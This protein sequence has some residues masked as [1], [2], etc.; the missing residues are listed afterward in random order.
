MS[1][2]LYRLGGL[3]ARRAWLVLLVWACIVA[4]VGAGWLLLGARTSNDIRLPGT[5]TQRATD[6]LAREF[7]PQQNGQS[8]VVFHVADGALTDPRAKRSVQ[9]SVRRMRAVPHVTS[10]MSPFDRGARSLLMSDDEKTAVAQVLLDVNGGQV[11]RALA[12]EVMAAA[13]PARDAGIQVEAGGVLGVRLSEEKSRRSEMI[14][15]GVGIVILAVTFGTLA[16]AGMPIVTAVVALVTGLGLIGLLGHVADIPV[17]APTLATMLGLGVGIDYALFIVF[18]YRDELHGG[19]SVREAVA[20]AMATSGSAVVF[21][22]VTVII[23]LLSLLVARVPLLGAM[24]WASALAVLVAVLTAITFLPA[25]LA[26]VGRRIDALRL[27]WRRRVEH[28]PDGDNIWARWAGAVTRH[29]WISLIAS[30]L[31]LLPLAAPTLTLILGQEDIGA[32]PTSTTQRRAYDL[33]SAGLGPGANGRFLVATGFLPAAEPSAGYTAE[34][35]RAERLADRLEKDAKRLKR[36]GKALERRGEGLKKDEA[37]LKA[38]GASVKAQ[39]ATLGTRVAPLLAEKNQLLAQKEQLVAEE[40][41]L[42]AQKAQLAARGAALE[43]KGESLA[44][45]IAAVQAQI[46]QTTDPVELAELQAQLMDLLQQAQAVQAQAAA[47]EKD[48]EALAK[49]AAP[50]EAEGRRL[51][52]RGRSLEVRSAALT[53]E[54][55][56]LK[57]TAAVLAGEGAALEKRAARLKKDS[58]ALRRDKRR[59]DRQAKRARSLKRDLVRMLTDAGGSPRATDPRLVRLQ[60]ALAAADGVESVSPPSVNESGSA[61]VFAI[62]ATTRPADPVTSDLVRHLRATVIPEATGGAGITAHVGGV[63]AAYDDLAALIS[64]RLPL[65]IGVVLALSFV[66]LLVAFRSVLV[67]LKAILCNLLAVGAAFGILTAFFQWGW[68]LGLV[69]LENAYGT[70]PIASYVPLIMFAVLF[71]M[72]T[73]YEVFLI[74]QIFHAHAE[75]MDTHAAVRTGVGSSARVITAAA[76]IMVTVFASFTLTSDPIIKEFGV[77]LSIAILLDATIVRLVIVPSTMVLLGEWNWWLPRWLEWLPQ[78]DLPDEHAGEP[79]VAGETS[80]GAE[81]AAAG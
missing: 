14:G 74:S 34:K 43:A 44:A 64:S 5:E 72:S 18:R 2:L 19:A 49:R 55:E 70:V 20:R 80:P 57:A 35:E 65:V 23:A 76:I 81:P 28:A 79:A 73:D 50:L 67:P 61:A 78:V 36:Q 6:F 11:T 33:V 16:A 31:V 10:A 53:A 30:L 29:P 59:L 58:A 9:E 52:E 17:V 24:G 21:A 8:A 7:A 48:A 40:A 69:G 75:G 45:Q 66:V 41:R 1:S 54:G 39:Q 4:L 46:A 56:A 22:G 13:Q 62:T 77:G 12:S 26:V 42:L 3:C 37:A 27:P 71:G 25:V 15:L 38:R 68:G 60:D 63:T 47:L 32:W 51:E